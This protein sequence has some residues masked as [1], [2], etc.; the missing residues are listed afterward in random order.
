MRPNTRVAFCQELGM[1]RSRIARA[2]REHLRPPPHLKTLTI[3]AMREATLMERQDS[4]AAHWCEQAI[5]AL[6]Q[7]EQAWDDKEAGE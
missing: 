1:L 3:A 4:A 2:Q 6:T 5:R 7:A